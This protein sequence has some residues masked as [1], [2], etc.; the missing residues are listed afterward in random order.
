[1]FKTV[2][3]SSLKESLLSFQILAKA[4]K[5]EDMICVIYDDRLD[6]C[7]EF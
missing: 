1:M 5:K 3:K 2:S 6:P 4:L 7:L